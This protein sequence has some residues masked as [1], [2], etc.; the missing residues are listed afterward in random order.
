MPERGLEAGTQPVRHAQHRFSGFQMPGQRRDGT[1]HQ[2]VRHQ[3]HCRKGVRSPLDVTGRPGTAGDRQMCADVAVEQQMAQLMGQ[4]EPATEWP[5]TTPM[6]CPRRFSLEAVPRE[7]VDSN[8]LQTTP[9]READTS[10]P[11]RSALH[12]PGGRTDS[13]PRPTVGSYPKRGWCP[14]PPPGHHRGLERTPAS[15]RIRWCPRQAAP[16][17][18]PSSGPLNPSA[19]GPH[20]RYAGG[21]NARKRRGLSTRIFRIVSSGTPA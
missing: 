15:V 10:G 8:C 6:Q 20:R 3:D 9:S 21:T 17:E 12:P 2:L 1:L 18:C 16:I 5:A 11:N 14:T 19:L 7:A 13:D 4:G